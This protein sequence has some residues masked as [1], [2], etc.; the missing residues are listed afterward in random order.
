[1]AENKG[2]AQGLRALLSEDKKE[3]KEQ[4]DQVRFVALTKITPNPWQPRRLFDEDELMDLQE[5]IAQSG[6]LSPLL[7][8]PHGENYLL[9]AG[10]RRLRAAKLAGLDEVPVL[11]KPLS[12]EEMAQVALVENIQRTQL[13]PLEEALGYA[14]LMEEYQRSAQEVAE[15]VGKSRPYIA[16]LVRLLQLPEPVQELL[17]EGKLSAGH[18]RALLGLKDEE[19]MVDMAHL[20]IENQLSVRG[21]E[22]LVKETVNFQLPKKASKGKKQASVKTAKW[23]RLAAQ[24]E[25][26]L[27]TKVSID[28]KGKVG[29]F[30][31]EFYGE[32]DLTRILDLLKLE[33]Y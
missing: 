25:N 7:V 5:S 21:T 9:I 20:V 23:D 31:I 22:A 1:M 33:G 19:T 3:G 17:A 18:G 4:V 30:T 26:Q 2:L 16:N 8:A 13:T 11:I 6:I 12:E 29:H 28:E 15:A 24:I 14:R 27:Q 32:E 10:E